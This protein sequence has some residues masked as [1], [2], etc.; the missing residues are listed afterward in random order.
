MATA[1]KPKPGRL[2]PELTESPSIAP[3]SKSFPKEETQAGR[4]WGGA[5]EPEFVVGH[6]RGAT[7]EAGGVVWGCGARG[8]PRRAP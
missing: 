8:C 7:E 4:G 3:M 1:G 5:L 6:T 2:F